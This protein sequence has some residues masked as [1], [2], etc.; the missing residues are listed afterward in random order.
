[1]TDAL[2]HPAAAVP[3]RFLVHEERDAPAIESALAE[4]PAYAAYALGHLEPGLVEQARFWIANGDEGQGVL[5]HAN[6]ALGRTVCVA[7][8]PAAVGALLAL[9]PGPLQSYL[10]TAAPEHLPALRR[11]YALSA[12][13]Q[14]QR[15]ATSAVAFQPVTGDVRRLAGRDARALNLLYA[16]DGAPTGYGPEHLERAVY[17]GAFA[18]GRLVAAAGTHVV[19]PHAGVAVVGNVFTHPQFRGMG[20][21]EQVTSAV[22]AEL[23]ER[24]CATVAL[25]VNPA[26]TPAVRAYTRLGYRAGAAVVEARVRRRDPLGGAAAWRRWLARR[27]AGAA[28]LEA[29]GRPRRQR[30]GGDA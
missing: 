4:D 19:A 20:L 2:Y 1:V 12:T 7:G 17:F 26:N 28:G 25:T 6:G 29:S 5:M 30:E 10:S 11:T 3:P 13:I 21:A 15:M 8:A 27:A 9:H 18:A 22:T 14:M 23:L 16:T 24:G